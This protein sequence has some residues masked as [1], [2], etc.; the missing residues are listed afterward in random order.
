KASRADITYGTNNEFGFDYLRDNMKFSLK[1][2]AQRELNYA[3]V[4]EVDSILIDEARTPLIISGPA[5]R[6]SNLYSVAD[7][8]ICALKR[9]VDFEVDEKHKAVHLTEA[10][11]DKV[12]HALGIENLYSSENVLVL[13]HVQQALRAHS[14]FKKDVDY[15]V[16]DDEVLIVD[17]FTGRILSGRRYSDGLHQ[18]LEAKERVK[19]ERE[20][21]TLATITLQ[22]YFRMYKKIAGMTGTAET[23]AAEFHKI[24]KL[25]VTAVPTNKPLVRD[26]Q[27][28]AIFL[29]AIDK[30]KAVADDIAD[31]QKRGQPVLV[32]TVSIEVSEVISHL[33]SQRGIKHEVL[34][35]KQH[36]REAEIVKNAGLPGN[37]TI[38]TNMAGR[39]TD[40]KLTKESLEAGGLKIIGT[41]RHEA[42]RIDN[43]LR[44]RSGRQGDPGSSKFY[45]SLDDDLVRIFAGEKLKTWMLRFG[46][47]EGESIEDPWITKSIASA[48]DRVEKGN[49]SVRKHL[50]EYDDVMNQQ[51]K[52]I[53]R[54][55]R[56]ILEGSESI[57]ELV[58]EI[59]GDMVSEIFSFAMPKGKITSDGEVEVYNQLS[60]ITGMSEE[61]LASQDFSRRSSTSLET[62]IV[63][64]LCLM[65]SQHRSAFSEEMVA[66]AEKWLLLETVDF[67]WKLHLQHLDHLKDS[68]SF[69]G[70]AQKNPLVEYKREA[71]DAFRR[72]MSQIKLDVSTGIFK[73]RP[74]SVSAEAIDEIEAER[75]KE[76]DAIKMTG[77]E[78][79]SKA[80]TVRRDAPKVGRNSPCPCGS[81]KKFKHCC[82]R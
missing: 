82:A 14:I 60:K 47:E 38:A 10:G 1:D 33:L 41:E 34:N 35:A 13:H 66:E 57:K 65:Y 48:Q 4:D 30:Y 70:Y 76:L 28:D 69:R 7:R 26:D 71:F 12:E 44:G 40:I 62:D 8:V 61:S 18:A 29:S 2:Y 67:A 63:D 80:Q 74:D 31:C 22:N 52:V 79:G 17:E 45:L 42:R 25:G 46:M 20:N 3:I 32:G 36:E 59:V 68:V 75:K 37:I 56:E 24:Y 55:R 39:G 64:F 54:Y 15:V 21:Q 78:E 58:K 51:R 72:M 9:D 16:R 23:E 50:L 5:E 43:Q 27:Q 19:I 81:G 73:M 11:T 6:G 49:F 77:A 53:Y